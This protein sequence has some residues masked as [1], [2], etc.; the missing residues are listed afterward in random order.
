MD[1]KLQAAYDKVM[2]GANPA[3]LGQNPLNQPQPVATT[4][5]QPAQTPPPIEQ[6]APQSQPQ[7]IPQ[8]AA[9]QPNQSSGINSTIAFNAHNSEVNKGTTP[10]KGGGGIMKKILIL[11]V[12][13]VL[14][15]A[16]TFVWIY[17]L[18]LDVPFLPKF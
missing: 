6:A 16:Y 13:L 14:L 2:N 1:P 4:A 17:V 18:K 10:V 11:L 12:V 9:P 3:N 8:P 7:T 15:V 5:Q